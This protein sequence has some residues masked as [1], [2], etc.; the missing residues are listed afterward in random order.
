MNMGTRSSQTWG[1]I[2][3]QWSF[4]HICLSG[5]AFPCMMGL[6]SV[7]CFQVISLASPHGRT[8]RC[9]TWWILWMKFAVRVS[10]TTRPLAFLHALDILASFSGRWYL[11]G[12]HM[13][14][15]YIMVYSS[16]HGILIRM[17]FHG[18]DDEQWDLGGVFFLRPIPPMLWAVRISGESVRPRE[19]SWWTS[20]RLAWTLKRA[21]QLRYTYIY[22]YVCW[23]ESRWKSAFDHLFSHVFFLHVFNIS[24]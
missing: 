14:P 10:W 23:N 18:T 4:I 16:Y 1:M 17:I 19:R 9:C 12:Y 24:W 21:P 2:I 7:F 20:T 22:I 3:L 5:M 13:I 6:G 8:M 15:W 11:H